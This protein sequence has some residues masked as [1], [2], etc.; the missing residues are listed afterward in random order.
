M[1]NNLLNQIIIIFFIIINSSANSS[2]QFNFDVTEIEIVD[3]GNIY[4]GLNRGTITTND[5]IELKADEFEYN[6]GLN[7]LEANGN[8][9]IK[10]TINKYVIFSDKITYLKNK[11]IIITNGN[12]R[13]IEED[14]NITIKANKFEYYKL[15]NKILASENVVINN[16]VKDYKIFSNKIEYFKNQEKFITHGFTRALIESNYDIK[17][18]DVI[19]FRDKLELFS[20]KDTTI[21][22]NNFQFYK[23]SKFNYS[24]NKKELKGEKIIVTTNYNLPKSDK[25]YFSSAIID[26][27]NNNF[28]AGDT[29]ILVHKNIFSEEENDPRI[30]G[31]SSNKKGNLT[32]IKK[33]IFTSC[34]KNDKCPPWS[35]SARKIE[36]DQIKKQISYD[37]AILKIY[38]KPV[39]Y[40]PK[41]FHPDPTVIRQSGFLKPT[42]NHS[43]V[44]GS[45]LTLPYYFKMSENKDFT[46]KPSWFDNDILVL[47]NEYRQINENSE[48][49]G[50]FGI[51]KGFR[52]KVENTR[53]NLNHIF[54]KFNKNLNLDNF[55]SSNLLLTLEKTNNDTYL[56]IF[57]AHITKSE[58]RP[59][60]LSSLKNEI[61]VVLNHDDYNFSS[62]IKSYENLD[63]TKKSDKYQ[64]VLPYYNFDRLI[65]D[66]FLNGSLNFSSAGTND[67]NNTNQLKSNIINN[68]SY[69]SNSF[70]TKNGISN[71]FKVNIKNLNS[72]GKNYSNYK[73]SPQIEMSSIFSLNS[74]YPL[75]KNNQNSKSFL[76][77]K[78]SLRFNPSDMKDN[79]SSKNKIN[80]GNIFSLNRLGLSDT[81]ESGRS[82]TLGL[83]Y[84]NEKKPNNAEELNKIN[85]YFEIKLA[86]VL[87][88]KEE[89]F[90]S[91]TS[92]INR[93]HSNIFGSIDRSFSD[94]LKFGYDF[95]LDNDFNKFE[96]NSIN[97]V[98]SLGNLKTNLSFIEEDGE[99]GDNNIFENTTEYS[100]D[101]LNSIKFKTRRN[102]K[103]DLTE[104]YDLIYEYK[105]DCLTA[106][107]KYNKTYYE[108]RDLKPT[109]N[110]LFTITLFPLTTYEYQADEIL[111]N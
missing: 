111:E 19:F 56:K 65:S 69:N 58:A 91:R 78:A 66:N 25:F 97:A 82:L 4:K 100:F 67:L 75:F 57:D 99:I 50:D 77:P 71:D 73:S 24:I 15:E 14:S 22:D 2:E 20:K 53:K 79:S 41:F 84:R 88:D 18:S 16:N 35:I 29:E 49:L 96:Y 8:V 52:S 63:E 68:F 45:S 3:K 48:F 98:F 27:K 42:V 28:V 110:L 36:H 40:F 95:A 70:I 89:N 32:S 93:K 103:I 80:V 90:I 107:I 87:R 37:Q 38:D 62:G 5:G 55:I 21:F 51:V 23:L 1:K 109:E 86:T 46:F 61:K 43:D 92:T 104:Y 108:D 105:N 31:V 72:L 64:Y 81:L 30:L 102:R 47:Q 76:T 11:N 33:G 26:L 85:K 44:L 60:S 39:L 74:S 17:S 7:V 54:T 106:G 59:E 13:A 10:D 6:K 94:N 83:D 34:K 9:K 12:S 101:N